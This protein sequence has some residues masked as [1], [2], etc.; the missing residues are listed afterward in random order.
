[1]ISTM[2]I[3]K[4]ICICISIVLPYRVCFASNASVCYE[5]KFAKFILHFDKFDK[6]VLEIFRKILL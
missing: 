4:C 3:V 5:S 6:L 1:M 2:R